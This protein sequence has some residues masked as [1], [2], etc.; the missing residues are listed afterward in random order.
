LLTLTP[1]ELLK[2][3]ASQ[4]MTSEMVIGQL[5]QNQIRQQAAIEAITIT[6]SSLRIDIDK[7]IAYIGMNPNLR[8]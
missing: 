2:L 7:V 6:L 1:N 4:Q 3:W 5:I 8:D